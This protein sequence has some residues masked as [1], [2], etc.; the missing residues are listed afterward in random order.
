MNHIEVNNINKEM[1]ADL[2]SLRLMFENGTATEDAVLTL[3]KKEIKVKNVYT[4]KV[5]D[6]PRAESAQNLAEKFLQQG[7]NAEPCENIAEAIKKAASSTDA[8][9]ICG[10]LYLYK[11]LKEDVQ[12]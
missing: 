9:L 12:N 10:S 3:L 8:T 1:P 2:E 5:K 11:D 7:L 6:N 4:V